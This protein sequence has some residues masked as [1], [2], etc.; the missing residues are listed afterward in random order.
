VWGDAAT[1]ISTANHPRLWSVALTVDW[2]ARYHCRQT[3]LDR[4]IYRL[5]DELAHA[6]RLFGGAGDDSIVGVTKD[7][8]PS[9]RPSVVE[10]GG[11]EQQSWRS[12]TVTRRQ[13][14]R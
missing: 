8:R 12:N 1:R 13:K 11:S 4:N 9:G 14:A 2:I 3:P 6:E 10:L 5:V 7:M